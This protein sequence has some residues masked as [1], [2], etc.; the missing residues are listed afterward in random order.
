MKK[1][2][3]VSCVFLI[4]LIPS[5]AFL[6]FL[7]ICAKTWYTQKQTLAFCKFSFTIG[8]LI[9]KTVSRVVNF[10]YEKRQSYL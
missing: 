10:F 2:I 1:V 4:I 6:F 7:L 8:K 5:F 3:I 9:K